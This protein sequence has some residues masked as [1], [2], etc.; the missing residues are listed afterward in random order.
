MG[1][2]LELGVLLLVQLLATSFFARF[3]IETPAMRKVLKWFMIHSI[4]IGLYFAI[5]HF[6]LLFPVVMISLGI[7]VHL[8]ITR[9]NGN[10]SDLSNS[11]K[12][13]LRT[14]RVEMV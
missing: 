4:T 13:I 7:I 6:A 9:K 1:I 12:E 11:Q 8:R 14:S 2:E 3:E 10:R 5:G